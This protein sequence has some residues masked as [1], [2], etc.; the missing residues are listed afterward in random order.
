MK[1]G[2]LRKKTTEENMQERER[3]EESKKGNK[4]L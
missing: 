1:P 3:K 2:K 4:R